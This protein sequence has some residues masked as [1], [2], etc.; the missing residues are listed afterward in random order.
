ME[1]YSDIKQLGPGGMENVYLAT[2]IIPNRKVVIKKF[3]SNMLQDPNLIKRLEIQAKSAAGLDHENIIRVFDFGEEEHSF[4]IAMEYISGLDLGR[5]M[6]WRPFP[7]EIGLM[8][9]VQSLK[10]L[11]YAHKLGFVHR[12]IKPGNILISK[13]GKVKVSDFGFDHISQ[14]IAEFNESSSDFMTVNYTPPEAIGGNGDRNISM[15]IWSTGVLAYHI[16]CGTLPFVGSNFQE[17]VHSILHDEA[18][19][20]RS[21]DP[22]LPDSLATEVNACL[23][24][25]SHSQEPQPARY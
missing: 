10:G 8:I 11:K 7:L 23:E 18:K 3:L 16:I 6:R 21:A 14:R 1:E 4:F 9:L 2:Q 22:T 5:L 13:T 25:K 17:L 15:D 20:V 19:D 24:K 12:N